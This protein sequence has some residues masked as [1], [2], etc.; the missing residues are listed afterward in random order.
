M[1]EAASWDTR[2]DALYAA[3][4][5]RDA[6]SA[7]LAAFLPDFD[8]HRVV[9]FSTDNVLA[10]GCHFIASEG[11]SDEAHVTYHAHYAAEDEWVRAAV[12]QG[13]GKAGDVFLGGE[14]V[15]RETLSRTRFWHEYCLPH[16]HFDVAGCVLEAPQADSSAQTYLSFIRGQEKALIR[17]SAKDAARALVPHARRVLALH[18]RLAP[19]LAAGSSLMDLFERMDLPMLF[20]DASGRVLRAN[21]VAESLLRDGRLIRSTTCE[22]LL[23]RLDGRWR[24]LTSLLARLSSEPG[25]EMI[26]DAELEHGTASLAAHV[27]TIQRASSGF[28]PLLSGR[29]PYAVLSLKPASP[30]TH[31]GL[32]QGYFGLTA[33]ELCVARALSEGLSAN[34]IASNLGVQLTTVRTHIASLLAKTGSQRQSAML[35]RLGALG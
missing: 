23:G 26:L 11:I 18:R 21:H 22:S 10:P 9:I 12:A 20:V 14:L 8:A 15:S 31:G 27:L 33:T 16:G 3:A 35:R 30:R 17:P 19:Q 29:Q 32:L 25:F 1:I 24:T 2:I 28:D 7:A 5:D 34:D 13:V 6:L 4:G